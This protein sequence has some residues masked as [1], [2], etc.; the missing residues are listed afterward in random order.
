MLR[1]AKKA[2]YVLTGY[3]GSRLEDANEY[4][5]DRGKLSS[6]ITDYVILGEV[7]E[8]KYILHLEK[9]GENIRTLY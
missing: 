9:N 2:I 1:S 5:A 8:R 7:S 3:L 4:W 6:D